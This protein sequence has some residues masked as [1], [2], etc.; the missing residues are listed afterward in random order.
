MFVKQSLLVSEA[1]PQRR[2]ACLESN[3]C[4]C[5]KLHHSEGM[6]V[7]KAVPTCVS[8]CINGDG[9]KEQLSHFSF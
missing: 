6:H 2:S 8:E 1:P 3:L 5:Q 9:A 7:W 4:S